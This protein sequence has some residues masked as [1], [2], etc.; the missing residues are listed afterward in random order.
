[1]PTRAA[2][3]CDDRQTDRRG[4]TDWRYCDAAAAAAA[5]A[6]SISRQMSAAAATGW[7]LCRLS[8]VDLH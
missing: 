8:A 2:Y 3:D 5:A 1:M 7:R 6:V 4:G